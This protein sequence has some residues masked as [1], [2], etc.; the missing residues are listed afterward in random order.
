MKS[1]LNQHNETQ[2]HKRASCLLLASKW[3]SPS[4]T[5][6]AKLK[7]FKC[8]LFDSSFYPKDRSDAASQSVCWLSQHYR[9][10]ARV[11]D[12]D[13]V[14]YSS[15]SRATTQLLMVENNNIKERE[16]LTRFPA[17]GMGQKHYCHCLLLRLG[18]QKHFGY[19]VMAV[20]V[21]ITIIVKSIQD[22]KA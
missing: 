18:Q 3:S 8:R 20:Y 14:I 9:R 4:E 17:F 1:R 7:H 19:K 12:L 16:F 10:A 13:N 6:L 15:Q 2:T 22:G 21:N 5:R 11:L